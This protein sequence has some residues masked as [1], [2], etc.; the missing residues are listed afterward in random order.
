MNKI[1]AM[2]L[3]MCTVQFRA[4]LSNT[5]EELKRIFNEQ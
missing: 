2:D 1:D 4:V 5:V 3:H